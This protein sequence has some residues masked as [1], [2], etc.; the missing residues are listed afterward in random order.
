MMNRKGPW[1]GHIIIERETS[2]YE[3]GDRVFRP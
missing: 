2:G 3:V 1:E